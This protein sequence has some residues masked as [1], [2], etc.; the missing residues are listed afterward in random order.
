MGLQ[1]DHSRGNK[2]MKNIYLEKENV[3]GGAGIK[4]KQKVLFVVDCMIINK[5]LQF[6]SG[7]FRNFLVSLDTFEN[8]GQVL[9]LLPV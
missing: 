8:F 9:A 4:Y 3:F 7:H 6:F 2:T 1:M 5:C